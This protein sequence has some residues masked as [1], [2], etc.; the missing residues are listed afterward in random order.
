MIDVDESICVASNIDVIIDISSCELTVLCRLV[1]M[2]LTS[3]FTTKL[4]VEVCIF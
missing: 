4:V 3:G 1:P 2:V